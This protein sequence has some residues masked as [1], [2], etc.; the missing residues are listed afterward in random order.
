MY[1][2]QKFNGEAVG[3]EDQHYATISAL[4]LKTGKFI[5]V[6]GEI[7]NI[8]EIKGVKKAMSQKSIDTIRNYDVSKIN[9]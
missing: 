3:M 7:I 6:G 8:S 1:E 9:L 4:L 2:I 5:D